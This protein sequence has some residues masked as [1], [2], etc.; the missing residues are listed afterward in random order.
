MLSTKTG[1]NFIKNRFADDEKLLQQPD[2]AYREMCETVR[3]SKKGEASG[4]II[5]DKEYDSEYDDG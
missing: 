3:L 4:D 5:S 1:E 2:Q